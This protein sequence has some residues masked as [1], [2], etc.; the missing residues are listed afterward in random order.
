MQRLKNAICANLPN[1]NH[2]KADAALQL[3]NEIATEIRFLLSK[4]FHT[5]ASE[6]LIDGEH[7]RNLLW[8]NKW[9]NKI[10]KINKWVNNKEINE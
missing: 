7:D 6:A 8:I 2:I 4:I 9:K 5:T 1:K 3:M 10:N